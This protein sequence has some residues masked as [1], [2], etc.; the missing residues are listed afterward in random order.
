MEPWERRE[1]GAQALYAF[2]GIFMIVL[3]LTI[4]VFRSSPAWVFY[5]TEVKGRR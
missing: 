5:E 4:L 1:Y 3:A 2:A